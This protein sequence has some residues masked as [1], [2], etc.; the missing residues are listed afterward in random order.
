MRKKVCHITSAHTRYDVRIFEKECVSLAKE[1]YDVYLIVNDD[2]E[3][4]VRN[5]VNIVSTSYIP[6]N[7]IDRIFHSTRVVYKKA[8]EVNA[9]LYHFHDPELLFAGNKLKKRGKKVI[10]DAHENVVSQIHDKEW[11]PGIFRNMSAIVYSAIQNRICKNL[12]AIIS[13]TPGIIKFYKKINL[14]TVLVTNYPIFEEKEIIRKPQKQVCFAGTLN[15]TWSHEIVLQALNR[16]EGITYTIAGSIETAY[17]EELKKVSKDNL[18][19]LGKIPHRKV[20]ELYANS[21]AGMAVNRSAQAK[22][23]DGSL[24]NTKIFE[25]MMN[26]VPVICTNFKI[27]REI[28]EENNC[29]I[30]VDMDDVDQIESAVRFILDNPEKACTMGKNGRN[31]IRKKYNWAHEEEKLFKLYGKLLNE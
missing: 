13:V 9:D 27:W 3:D 28:V 1:G 20:N 16:I 11:I 2:K 18:N 24:G 19:Y 30:C 21:F 4:E 31:L 26:E 17:L 22:K 23:E 15:S 5:G 25:F 12:D 8:L 7:R 29:G 14:N 10:F 6:K